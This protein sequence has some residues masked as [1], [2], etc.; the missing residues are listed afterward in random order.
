MVGVSAGEGMN[1]VFNEG[2]AASAAGNFDEAIGK[3][4]EALKTNP[5]CADCYYN[6][7]VANAGKKD[8]DKAEEA[9]K[10]SIE[11]KPSADAYNGLASIYTGQRKLDLAAEAGKKAAELSAASPCGANPDASYNQGVIAFN[12]GKPADAKGFLQ[13]TLAAKPDHA[14]AHFL[15]GQ[16]LVGE[17]N[18]GDAVKEYETYLKLTPSGPNAKQAQDNVTALKP[19]VK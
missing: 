12:A 1:K 13:A 5:Q 14:E 18:F 10:K 15:L 8:L 2:V 4:N 7:G 3:F 19:L 9:Y 17:G 6:I 11:V 16:V